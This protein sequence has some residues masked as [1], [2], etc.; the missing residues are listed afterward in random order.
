MREQGIVQGT[1]GTG[2]H[3]LERDS[4]FLSWLGGLAESSTLLAITQALGAPAVLNSFGAVDNRKGVDQY[5]GHV[6]RDVRIHTRELRLMTQILVPLD[7]FNAETGAT[8]LLPASHL[9]AEEPDRA[10]FFDA[11]RQI[12]ASPGQLILF[13][14]RVWHAAGTNVTENPRRAL[15]LTFTRSFIKPQFDYC[16]YLGYDYVEH[17]PS[18]SS[19]CSA[20][21]REFRRRWAS[22]TSRP[23]RASIARVRTDRRVQR[24]C[25]PRRPHRRLRTSPGT[26]CPARSILPD[27][28]RRRSAIRSGRRTGSLRTA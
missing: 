10:A 14:S 5:V 17:C 4:V 27:R 6:H 23:S 25:R 2:H 20:S 21:S 8:W 13:D 9:R 12:C 1:A 18:R 3:L 28:P 16:R 24:Q 22:G 19:S 11:A 26:P 7:E 15:T